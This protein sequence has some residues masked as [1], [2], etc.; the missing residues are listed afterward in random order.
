MLAA[1]AARAIQGA[2][3]TA[4]AQVGD[5]SPEVARAQAMDE[6]RQLR[7][8]IRTGERL[9]DELSDNIE[10]RGRLSDSLQTIRDAVTEPLLGALNDVMEALVI[11]LE[12]IAD[13]SEAI[14]IGVDGALAVLIGADSELRE[15]RRQMK[16]DKEMSFLDWFEKQPQV[17]PAGFN[18]QG[19]MEVVNLQFNAIPGLNL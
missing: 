13:N 15:L 14:K 10:V 8:N 4:I 18:A 16:K 17:V 11:P 3:N 12:L 19:Q 1:G 7:A 9:G 6:V 5:L 2:A